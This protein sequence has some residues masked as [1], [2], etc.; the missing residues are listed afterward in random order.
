[1]GRTFIK[2][3]NPYAIYVY[4]DGAMDYDK[5]NTGG[6]GYCISFPDQIAIEPIPITKGIY[7]GGNIE[8]LEL[9]ALIQSMKETL[10]VLKI[11]K[12]EIITVS[13]VIF[14]TDRYGLREEDK[15]SAYRIKDWR[16]N[17]WKNFEGKP[18]KNH[19]LLDELDKV[20]MKLTKE[21][22]VKVNIE[23]RPRKQNKIADRLAK[24]GKEE[25]TLNSKLW[26]K[27]DKI[28]KRK[29]DDVEINYKKLIVGN[30]YHIHV[31]KKEPVQDKWEVWVEICDGTDK[32]KK[33][34]IY[35][36]DTQAAILKRRNEFI[37]I[38]KNSFRYHILIEDKIEPVSNKADIK[39]E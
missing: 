25:G 37:V 1:M 4:C 15:T 7:V 39:D 3:K 32:G 17:G 28:G 24:A 26:S 22:K 34:K 13:Q 31:F 14:V 8:R 27:G 10:D 12:A 20:R 23:Y 30:S 6:V 9:E 36:N 16:R 33:L 35:C 5:H 11:Y 38:L 19:K 29:F 21:A 2:P 18:I